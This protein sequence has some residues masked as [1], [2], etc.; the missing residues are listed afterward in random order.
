MSAFG[1]N[2]ANSKNFEKGEGLP[3]IQRLPPTARQG[4]YSIGPY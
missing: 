4:V 1:L 3:A 2:K